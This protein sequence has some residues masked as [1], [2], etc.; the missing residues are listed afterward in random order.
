[1]FKKLTFL[2][3]LSVFVAACSSTPSIPYSKKQ[4]SFKIPKNY[5][6]TYPVSLADE[7][8][9]MA[10]LAKQQQAWSGTKYVLGGTT[11]KGVDCSGFTQ[12]MYRD[13]FAKNIPRMTVDQEK[14]GKKVAKR[15]LRAGD[16]VFFNT[17][18]GPNGKHV[19]IYI[20]DGLFLHA[21]SNGGVIYSHLDRS[22]WAKT[23]SQARRL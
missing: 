9:V 8:M 7:T 5:Q 3:I 23:F 6:I 14:V 10:S 12:V 19:G 2:T 16:L 17:G 21:S 11:K 13:L 22:Y 15:D 1:M 20:K 4:T 18:R